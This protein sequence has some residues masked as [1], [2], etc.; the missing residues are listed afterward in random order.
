MKINYS[1]LFFYFLFFLYYGNNEIYAQ[2]NNDSLLYYYNTIVSPK[3]KTDLL[4]GIQFYT[5]RVEYT[6]SLK[7]TLESINSLRMVTIGQFE[8]GDFLESEKN[9]VRTLHL[10]DE[11]KY[12]D[13][14]IE[15]KLGLYNQLGRIYRQSYKYQNAIDIYGQAL[16]I[17]KNLGDSITLLNNIAN[18]YKDLESYKNAYDQYQTILEKPEITSDS[19]KYAMALDNLG[20]VQSKMDS[21]DALYNL[22]KSLKIRQVINE[23]PGL[24]SSYKNLSIY[25]SDRNDNV[26]A[27][28]YANKAYDISKKIN[29]SLFSLDALGLI[30]DLNKDDKMK[31]YKKLRDSISKQK[32][33]NE[34]K[35][36]FLK[37]NVEQERKKTEVFKLSEE[38]EKR[39]KLFYQ[40]LGI[41]IISISLFLYF[42]LKSRHKKEKLQEVYTTEN[43]ISKKIH[44]EVANDVYQ[45]MTKLQSDPNVK[46]HVLDDLE[47]IYSKTREISKE[48]GVLDFKNDFEEALTDVL[49]R[50]NSDTVNVVTKGISSVQWGTISNLKKT[51]IY[52]ILQELMI[53][54]SKHSQASLV[55][56][57]CSQDRKKINIT[58]S[59]NGV[60]GD[61]KKSNGLQNVETRIELVDGSITF[62][63]EIGKGFKAKM[64]V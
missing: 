4:I 34:N 7:D 20:Y 56:V 40:S 10:I 19:F 22:G 53:N 9:I 31:I 27:L 38:K 28:F 49:L 39:Q 55:V 21:A 13:T 1:S 35:N 33:L 37:Y 63:S 25:H 45:V 23:V 44:D 64:S 60:G 46:E 8:I 32:Q 36:A 51:T 47:D 42:L 29:N 52:K 58:Y 15:S 26:K 24:F 43:K 41:L 54:M 50:H 62:E 14:L 57:S 48:R 12:G 5:E 3:E 11:F 18:I 6:L 17:S 16:L 59:D 30:I 61:I 2:H